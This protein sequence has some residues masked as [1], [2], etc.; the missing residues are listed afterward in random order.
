MLGDQWSASDANGRQS[1]Q[2][3]HSAP[4]FKY[5]TREKQLERGGCGGCGGG[6]WAVASVVMMVALV[7]A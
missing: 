3:T 6:L 1:S 7:T 4:S 2:M 5:S